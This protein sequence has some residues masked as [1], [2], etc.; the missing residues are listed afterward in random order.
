MLALNRGMFFTGMLVVFQISW[1]KIVGNPYSPNSQFI[2]YHPPNSQDAELSVPC[3][4]F[5]NS[6]EVQ[7]FLRM[8]T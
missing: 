8:A 7:D 5:V 1:L 4:G 2:H 3:W 6:N